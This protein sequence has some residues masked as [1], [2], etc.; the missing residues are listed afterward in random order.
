[1]IELKRGA[2][3]STVGSLQGS[4]G[5]GGRWLVGRQQQLWGKKFTASVNAGSA[6]GCGDGS[7]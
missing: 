3:E 7:I 6:S 4:L 1:M 2:K 5:N